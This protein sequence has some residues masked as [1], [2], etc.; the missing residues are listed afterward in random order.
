LEDVWKNTSGVSRW[1]M[2]EVQD[3]PKMYA[4]TSNVSWSQTP[5]SPEEFW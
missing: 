5:D 4:L 3:L 1:T 2:K